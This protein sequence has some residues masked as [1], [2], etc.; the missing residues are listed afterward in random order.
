ML[1]T[2]SQRFILGTIKNAKFFKLLADGLREKVK[3][4]DLIDTL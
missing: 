2:W 4:T 1:L 3:V